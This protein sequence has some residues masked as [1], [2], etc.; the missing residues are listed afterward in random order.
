MLD[1][2]HPCLGQQVTPWLAGSVTP[3]LS[4][5]EAERAFL[6]G[7]KQMKGWGEVGVSEE[8]MLVELSDLNANW[9]R[10]NEC[11]VHKINYSP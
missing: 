5:L 7:P 11:E 6:L 3:K 8:I 2:W 10:Y 1:V 4:W 9:M